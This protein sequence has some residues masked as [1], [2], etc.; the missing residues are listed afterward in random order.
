MELKSFKPRNP[1]ESSESPESLESPELSQPSNFI[2]AEDWDEPSEAPAKRRVS[3]KWLGLLLLG[4]LATGGFWTV[5]RLSRR[6]PPPSQR[7]QVVFVER[8]DMAVTI[9]ANGIV[10]PEQVVNISP[11]T[12]G[13]MTRLLVKEGDRVRAGQALAYMDDSNLR[14]QLTLAQ[15]QLAKAEA[16]LAKAIAG[17]RSQE[18]AQAEARLASA[19]ADLNL[20]E[21]N[22][23]RNQ[24]LSDAGAISRIEYDKFK[25]ERDT[26]QAKLS[27][28]QQ[29]LSLMQ[30]GS[31]PEE[32]AAA[33][34]QVI[35]QRGTL[36]TIEAQINDTVVRAPFD[37]VVSR[38][39]ADPG[40]FVAPTTAGSSVS[41]ATSSS[42]LSLASTNRVVANVSESKIAQVTVGQPVVITADAFPGK[43][44]QGRVSQVATQAIVEQNVTSFQVKVALLGNAPQ[45]LRSG[46]NISAQFNVGQ[47][48]DV[49]TVPSVAVTRKDEVTGVYVGA[50]QQP[51]RFVPITTG[52][53]IDNRTEVKSGL[54]GSEHI[55]INVQDKAPPPQGFSFSWSD[56]FGGSRRD[57]PP[58]GGPPGGPPPG[59]GRGPGGPGGPGGGGPGG[60]GGGSGGPP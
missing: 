4:L 2:D 16:E 57:G 28:V 47:L 8:K 13:I 44:F 6:P 27:E 53:T 58:G 48:K 20:A 49:L 37:G 34:A 39:Y 18:V 40:A 54:E 46:M 1:P 14:G 21:E 12:T 5:Q 38:K 22:L 17:N 24:Q 51:P 23:R 29:E 15:G 41:S 19:A 33:E 56:L 26:A 50:P 55:L 25:A 60:P 11:K 7:P 31:R 52:V 3:K 45:E 35:A 30:A 36:Q 9:S 42:I 10:E 43:T 32:I 59:G